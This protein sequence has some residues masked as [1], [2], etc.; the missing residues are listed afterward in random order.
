MDNYKIT[1]RMSGAPDGDG[2]QELMKL[3]IFW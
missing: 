3:Q 1:G 2:A